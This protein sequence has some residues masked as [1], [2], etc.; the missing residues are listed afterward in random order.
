MSGHSKWHSIK[1]KKGAADKA[2]GKLFA[3]LIRQIEV[4]ARAGGGDTR[5]Q[6]DAA[7]DGAEGARQLGARRHH[8]A[9]DQARH[10]RA[11][12]R[13][14]RAG[15]LRG[16]RAERRRR[17]RRVPHR[18]PQPHRAEVKNMFTR[19]GGS[20]AEPG[21]VAW[22]FE[23]KGVINL[24]KRA[25]TEDD[26]MLAALDAGAEDIV[27]E[28]DTWRIT[29]APTDLHAVRSRARGGRHPVHERRPHD[30]ADQ[31]VPLTDEASGPRRAAGDRRAR[32]ARR[33]AERVRQL[34]HPRR[35]AR[36][37]RRR[38]GPM[39]L[40]AGSRLRP[41][42]TT[43]PC[44]RRGRATATRSSRR[45]S[46]GSTPK[47]GSWSAPARRR[48]KVKNLRRDPR[49]SLCVLNDGFFG[50]WVQVDG[51]AE[52]VSLPEAMELLVE[53]YRSL[54][55][56][57]PDWDEYRAVDGTRAPRRSSAIEHR[58]GRPRPQRL[59]AGAR[60]GLASPRP[61]RGSRI[62]RSTGSRTSTTSSLARC[63]CSTCARSSG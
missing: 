31:T 22:Q 45:S 17:L 47:D 51:T 53:Y 21:A 9:R 49:V 36:G 7:H 42:A 32:G 23:R 58:A 25:A 33:R 38:S 11:R 34:R 56:E 20:L 5:R 18:Q 26:L 2:R 46:A 10:R 61:V 4:A 35:R 8:R 6:P 63:S 54:A 1:H 12:G 29:T 59:D 55:G 24:E 28:G 41:R 52:I 62:D 15:E 60:T 37:R 50:E 57:H 19:N 48:Y 16:L 27:D 40:D 13:P 43:T 3:K 39:D 44:W 14:L 30:A